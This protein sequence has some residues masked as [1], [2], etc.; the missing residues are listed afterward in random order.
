M[1]L[2]LVAA[3]LATLLTKHIF[4]TCFRCLLLFL[5]PDDYKSAAYRRIL[6]DDPTPSRLSNLNQQLSNETPPK[7]NLMAKV[8][9]GAKQTSN[10]K[11]PPNIRLPPQAT[12]TDNAIMPQLQ[13]VIVTYQLGLK[14]F[15]GGL[16][17]ITIFLYYRKKNFVRRG[18]HKK[19]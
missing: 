3:V 11:Q 9:V 18:L 1:Y 10:E 4:A 6:F 14:V 2:F 15:L 5:R 19:V 7:M 13:T 16:I 8:D 17:F 12:P